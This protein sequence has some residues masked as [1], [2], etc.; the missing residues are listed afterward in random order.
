VIELG[1][2]WEFIALAYGGTAL[3]VLAAIAWTCIDAERT[4]AHLKVL[5]AARAARETR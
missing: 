3:A 4:K 5:E 1:Q 2:H